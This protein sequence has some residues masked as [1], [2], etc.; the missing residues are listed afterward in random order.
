MS[1]RLSVAKMKKE[2]CCPKC[3]G[4]QALDRE[5][6]QSVGVRGKIL[7]APEDR[8]LYL[9]CSLCGY[10]EMYSMAILARQ[11]EPAT[12]KIEAVEESG[13]ATSQCNGES[14]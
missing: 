2:F 13:P 7:R 1:C 8:F 14:P 5:V 4:R 11:E 3:R 12:E 6:V 10:T 9:T